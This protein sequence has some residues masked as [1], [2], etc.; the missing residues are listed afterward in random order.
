MDGTGKIRKTEGRGWE[1]SSRGGG[2]EEWG[3]L[4]PLWRLPAWAREWQREIVLRIT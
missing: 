4:G 2:R 3:V 1:V